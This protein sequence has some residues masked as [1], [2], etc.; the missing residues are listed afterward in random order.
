[1]DGAVSERTAD[2][3]YASAVKTT[4]WGVYVP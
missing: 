2:L 4:M 1:V 3:L